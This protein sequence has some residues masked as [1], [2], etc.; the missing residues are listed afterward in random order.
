ML[1]NKGQVD[2]QDVIRC[3]NRSTFTIFFLQILMSRIRNMGIF[4]VCSNLEVKYQPTRKNSL[5]YKKNPVFSLF[6]YVSFKCKLLY[7]DDHFIY[8]HIECH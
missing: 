8:E 3:K 1:Q 6:S 2:L 5:L 7:F 4:I